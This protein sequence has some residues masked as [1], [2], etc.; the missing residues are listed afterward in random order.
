MPAIDIDRDAAREAA[1]HEL[2]K[3]IYPRG[4]FSDRIADWLHDLL[5]RLILHGS[6]LPGGWFT[7]TVLVL[8]VLAAVVVAVRIARRTMGSAREARLYDRRFLTAAEYR[9]RA[10]RFA[11]DGDWS[12][13]IRQRMR[14]VGRQLE[15]N[16]VLNPV[17]G[18][19]AG[20]LA[21]ETGQLLPGFTTE[22]SRAASRR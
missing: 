13:A 14:A 17:T 9:S 20:E 10:E 4:S 15:E 11:T 2:G 1:Q 18:R 21:R 16:G 6:S 7:I 12:A 19:T 22:L 5:F 8:L 3:P